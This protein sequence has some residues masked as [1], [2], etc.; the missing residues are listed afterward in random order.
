MPTSLRQSI[1]LIVLLAALA[2]T[3]CLSKT[4][5]PSI[6]ADAARLHYP[7]KFVWFDLYTTDMVRATQ[8]Y[9]AVFNWSFERTNPGSPAIKNILHEGM[10]IGNIHELE[11]VPHWRSTMSVSDIH[12]VYQAA[13]VAGGTEGVRPVDM[14]D[15]GMTAGFRDPEGVSVG[16]VAS[17]VG[18]PRD[19]SPIDGYWAGAELLTGDVQGAVRFYSGL[20]PYKLH[21]MNLGGRDYVLL[22]A[23]RRVRAGITTTPKDTIDPQ[24][25]PQ[26]SV[27]DIQYVMGRI[28]ANGGRM[29]VRPQEGLTQGRSAI[30][31]DPFG[32]LIGIREFQP[33]ED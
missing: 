8:F 26:V 14:P 4:V 31:E 20:A 32:A 24:W 19:M 11:G 33:V 25:V 21:A 5:M 6:T 2:V 27:R 1:S 13:L 9:D 18:D 29:I 16:L 22:V 30:F 3:G 23:N 10:V 17:P 15:R 12:G 28:E 7:G